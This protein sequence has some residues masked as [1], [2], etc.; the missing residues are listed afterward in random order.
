M[1]TNLIVKPI[2]ALINENKKIK[3]RKFKEVISV[4]SNIIEFIELSDS[5]VVMSQSID[6]YQKSQAELL[7]AIV[8]LIAEAVDAKSPYTGGHCKRVPQLAQMLIHEASHSNKGSF[9]E[10]SLSSED[11]LREFEIGAWLHDCGK[12]TTPE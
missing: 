10:F 6:E 7:N 9:K 2:K 1:A 5:F 12:V 8:K 11:E 4:K 3:L